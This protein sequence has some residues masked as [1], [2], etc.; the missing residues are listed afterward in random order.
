VP[1]FAA[2][3]RDVSRALNKVRTNGQAVVAALAAEDH[4]RRMMD[5][6]SHLPDLFRG[7]GAGS[8]LRKQISRR[9]ETVASESKKFVAPSLAAMPVASS[10]P[11]LRRAVEGVYIDGS[12][13]FAAEENGASVLGALVGDLEQKLVRYG[14][15]LE[16]EGVIG[17]AGRIIGDTARG[18]GK[19][20]RRV[21]E[22][23]GE[24]AKDIGKGAGAGLLDIFKGW[25]PVLLIGGVVAAGYVFGPALAARAV[26]R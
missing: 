17:G 4:G 14:K 26:A 22:G 19:G 16:N 25:W 13:V 11:T 24:G 23:V 12:A 20:V 3:V 6:A 9:L 21:E 5:R 7:A 8:V 18:V 2:Q 15:V 1:D 10:W